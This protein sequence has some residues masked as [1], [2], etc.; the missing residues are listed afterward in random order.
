MVPTGSALHSLMVPA[1]PEKD[2]KEGTWSVT[3]F[4]SITADT[5]VT[6][7]YPA[8]YIG[9]MDGNGKLTIRDVSRLLMHLADGNVT[10]HEPAD[11]DGDGQVNI[12]DATALLMKLAG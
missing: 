4:T 8:D 5:E 10:L 3:D 6:A 2:G 1:V 11:V 12:A 9:D 7:E